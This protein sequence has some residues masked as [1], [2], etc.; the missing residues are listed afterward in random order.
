M[1]PVTPLAV[2]IGA[3]IFLSR[4]NIAGLVAGGIVTMALMHLWPGI[5]M[6]IF[7]WVGGFLESSGLSDLVRDVESDLKQ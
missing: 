1:L 5:F 2:I 3:M 7:D 6:P 4:S